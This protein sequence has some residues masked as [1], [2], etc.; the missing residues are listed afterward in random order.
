MENNLRKKIYEDDVTLAFLSKSNDVF[1]HTLIIPKQH[2]HV[3]LD[4]EQTILNQT[5][6]TLKQVA[7]YYVEN[8]GFS[9]INILNTNGTAAEHSVPHLHFH[10]SPRMESDTYHAWP[11]FTAH[12]HSLEEAHQKLTMIGE[13]NNL[14]ID[15]ALCKSLSLFASIQCDN[16]E[17]YFRNIYTLNNKKI[18]CNRVHAQCGVHPSI[19]Q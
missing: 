19:G 9:E 12:T 14:E 1:G 2:V 3:L 13:Q 16:L 5:M 18:F 7:T 6:R 17:N 15:E 11:N 10:I 4:G 8:F